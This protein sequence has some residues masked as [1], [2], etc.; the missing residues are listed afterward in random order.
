MEGDLALLFWYK[1]CS[2]YVSAGVTSYFDISV[3]SSTLVGDEVATLSP[4][5]LNM[6]LVVGADPG[7]IGAVG[8]SGRS[9]HCVAKARF[10]GHSN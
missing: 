8:R 6:G 7:R 9:G 1:R 2:E 3:Y 5:G 4:V 10:P